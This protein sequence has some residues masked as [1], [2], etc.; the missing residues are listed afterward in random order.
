MRM[1]GGCTV[2][3]DRHRLIGSVGRI[4]FDFDIFPA[5]SDEEAVR[6]E[7]FDDEIDSIRL[8]DPLTGDVRGQ[9]P[10]MTIYPKSHYVT[11]RETILEAIDSIKAELKERL[12][13]L[14]KH[15]RLVEAQRLEQRAAATGA[16]PLLGGARSAA[17]RASLGLFT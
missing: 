3:N 2:G 12:E 15:E 13:W 4:I 8:F 7:L 17:G 16:G 9:V 11:P 6:V 10:R 5:D 1:P 14:R